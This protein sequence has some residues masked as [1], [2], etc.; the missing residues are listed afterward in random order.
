MTHDLM[1][2]RERVRH[3]CLVQEAE[4]AELIARMPADLAIWH[5]GTDALP[6]MLK[7]LAMRRIEQLAREGLHPA[8]RAPDHLREST[9]SVERFTHAA[10][11]MVRWNADHGTNRPSPV[12]P[13][14]PSN[15]QRGRQRRRGRRT[16]A[17]GIGFKDIEIA[18]DLAA[19]WEALDAIRFGLVTGDVSIRDARGRHIWIRNHRRADVEVL[20][21]LLEQ[22]TI[23][24]PQ[25]APQD[26]SQIRAW[27]VANRGHPHRVHDLPE[28][29]RRSA[30]RDAHAMLEEQG[31]SVPSDTDLGGLTLDEARACYAVL[32]AQLFINEL[33]AIHLESEASLVWGIKP[34]NL[35]RLLQRYVDAPVARAFVDLTRY[36][37]GRSPVS[38]PLIPHRDLLMIPAPLVSPVGFERTLLRAASADPGRTGG[39]GRVLGDR[40]R[41]W[42]QRL[43]SIPECEVAERVRV[44]DATGRT[45]GDLDVVAWDRTRAFAVVFET[46]WPID[47]ATLVEGAK[48]DAHFAS[49]RKQLGQVRDA[50][51]SRN[52]TPDWP[53]GW[54]LPESTA[55]SWWVGSAQQLDS[56]A[57]GSDSDIRTTSL[58]LVE[59]VL[60]QPNLRA[61]I[62]ALVS[63]PMPQQGA[64][65]DLV[66]RQ[67]E[68]GR[69]VLHFDAIEMHGKPP[70]PPPE[71]RRSAGWT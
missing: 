45:L 67:V 65:F 29:L 48:V 42:G 58:R 37:K 27:F 41:R 71:R 10:Q 64:D 62:D 31:T 7:L 19:D 51:A 38:A 69:Y 2:Q 20:D 66:P 3:T 30:W 15:P 61:F 36:A 60:P 70:V 24:N 56:T 59:Q 8:L 55:F 4:L 22:V 23:L 34:H 68:A 18:C 12:P 49:G 63:F 35:Q 50:L 44:K 17:R 6:T 40:A 54:D 47:A 57:A 5:S 39:L 11:S 46:K 33:C 32:I 53:R 14:H 52:A 26:L 28:S 21:I 1:Y 25:S 43:R 9:R 13:S 16:I